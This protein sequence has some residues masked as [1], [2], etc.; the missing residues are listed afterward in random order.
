VG[1]GVRGLVEVDHTV[2][3]ELHEGA[4]SRR[5]SAG[6]RGEVVSLHIQLVEVLS[7]NEG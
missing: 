2:A 3:L 4:R 6:Q 1:G 7:L 5:P